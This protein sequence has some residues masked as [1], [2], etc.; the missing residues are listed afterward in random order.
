[1]KNHIS[2][3]YIVLG[4]LLAVACNPLEEINEQLAQ[5][6]ALEEAKYAFLYDKEVA[7]AA[8]TLTDE[9]YAL[10]S[11]ESIVN[12]KNFSNQN[13]PSKYLPEILNQR[14]SAEDTE[15]MMV[16]YAYYSRVF[17]DYDNALELSSDDYKIAMG[18][19]Y[20]NFSD[21]DKAKALIAK[22]LDRTQY[23]TEAGKEITVAY[24]LYE[25][26]YEDQFLQIDIATG[27]YEYVSVE[28]AEYTLSSDDY[29]LMGQSYPNFSSKSTA[30]EEIVAFAQEKFSDKTS[31]IVE[32]VYTFTYHDKYVVY[33]FDGTQWQLA[34][35]VTSVTEELSY[36][37]NKEDIT[38]STWKADS[39]IKYTLTS[40][41][42]ERWEDNTKYHNFDLRSGKPEGD[43]AVVIKKIGEVLDDVFDPVEEGQEFLVTYNYYDGLTGSATIRV[44][45]EGGIWMEVK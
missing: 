17:V 34:T 23:E 43:F 26:A 3:I 10:S 4:F 12:Y 11:V 21:E 24:T 35:S 7:P 45:K 18:Q 6:E 2:K 38:K 33:R 9:D 42:Y 44:V 14:F 16:T 41:D 40:A 13:L 31:V 29:E 37:V 25:R 5:D 22:Y 19:S 1:M 8:Y 39:S 20:S 30:E 15:T 32:Y 27:A 36:S 28:E